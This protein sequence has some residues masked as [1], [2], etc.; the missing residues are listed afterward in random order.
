MWG[1][2]CVLDETHSR[3]SSLE[4]HLQS[5]Q[6]YNKTIESWTQNAC[7]TKVETHS[8]ITEESQI[9][10]NTHEHSQLT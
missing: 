7:T 1:E 5:P 3:R 9:K 2:K 8:H 6:S 10:V 4:T